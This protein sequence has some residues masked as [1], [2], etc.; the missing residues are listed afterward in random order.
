MRKKLIVSGCSFTERD[1]KSYIHPEM[2]TSYPKWPELLA[3]E[4]DMDC[5]NLG[6]GGQGNEYIYHT[7]TNELLKHDNS[8]IGLAIAAWTN[9]DRLDYMENGNWYR[10]LTNPHGDTSYFMYKSFM[11]YHMF[12]TFC[13]YYSVPYKHFQMIPVVRVYKDDQ[14]ITGVPGYKTEYTREQEA[15]NIMSSQHFLDLDG[16]NFIGYPII[17]SMNGY[18]MDQ[19]LDQR[20]PTHFLSTQDYHPSAIGHQILKNKIAARL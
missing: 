6:K 17:N 9:C 7:L 19:F 18:C 4:L 2:D 3:E 15:K 8:S 16:N 5:I 10:I 1:W 20:N 14:V 13:N 11:Y 12:Q